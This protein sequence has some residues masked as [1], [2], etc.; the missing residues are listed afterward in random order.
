[1]REGKRVRADMKVVR[2]VGRFR[3]I[4]CATTVSATLCSLLSARAAFAADTVASNSTPTTT[5]NAGLLIGLGAGVLIIGGIGF[6]ILTYSR[7]KRRPS[8]C[9]EQR[10]TLAAA[11]RALQYWEGA[12]AHIQTLDQNHFSVGAIGVVDGTDPRAPVTSDVDHETLRR[13]SQSG[14]AAAVQYRDQCQ[15]DLIRLMALGGGP[16]TLS[17]ELLPQPPVIP[18]D[19]P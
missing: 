2:W 15:L 19:Q 9:A 4:F 5:N 6:V 16:T 8:Q 18:F 3:R 12:L 13:K 17:G 1:M 11:E 10:D 14:Y 7:K